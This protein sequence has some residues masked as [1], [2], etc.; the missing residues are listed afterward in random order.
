MLIC[1]YGYWQLLGLI[2]Y[3]RLW[4]GDLSP[5]YGHWD[6]TGIYINGRLMDI[7]T[8]HVLKVNGILIPTRVHM[9]IMK[10]P[11]VA[12]CQRHVLS[13]TSTL[14]SGGRL[15]WTE[16]GI[17]LQRRMIYIVMEIS[18]AFEDNPMWRSKF[19]F[20]MSFATGRG[21][22]KLFWWG[23]RTAGYPGSLTLDYCKYIGILER[24]ETSRNRGQTGM[25]NIAWVWF[26][27]R[28]FCWFYGLCV[29]ARGKSSN[30]PGWF[31]PLECCRVSYI[32][33]YIH[34][35]RYRYRYRFLFRS[36][37]SLPHFFRPHFYDL[38]YDLGSGIPLP[39]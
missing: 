29:R 30:R 21:K 39:L 11:P 14:V 13:P 7:L 24:S 37:Q 10:H 17:I 12:G 2:Y 36:P 19:Q 34:R 35:Q 38:L 31:R 27:L 4:F 26:A 5:M 6:S 33:M 18:G 23:I 32:Y 8:N 25:L 22:P 9:K 1:L 28:S 3:I 16:E 15:M 20:H